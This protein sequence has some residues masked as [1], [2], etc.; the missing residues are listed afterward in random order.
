M[1][2]RLASAVILA[3]AVLALGPGW[4]LPLQSRR[5]KPILSIASTTT[6]L[7]L[8]LAAFA[9]AVLRW[10]GDIFWA[11]AAA[12]KNTITKFGDEAR[13]VFGP[14][15]HLACATAEARVI[16][17]EVDGNIVDLRPNI[18]KA[19][20]PLEFEHRNASGDIVKWTN[21]IPQM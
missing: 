21:S 8:D 3:S 6:R 18:D 19:G 13:S 15:P 14:I 11:P 20:H 5:E 1:M 7:A 4:G 10:N 16:P 17:V 9:A 12:S 2:R